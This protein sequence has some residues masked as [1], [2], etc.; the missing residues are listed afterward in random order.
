MTVSLAVPEDGAWLRI[1]ARRHRACGILMA[2][3]AK[4]LAA[5][6]FCLHMNSKR[7]SEWREVK[8]LRSV[9]A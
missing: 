2:A 4:G 7:G 3:W 1:I 5:R 8:D 9:F 6:F